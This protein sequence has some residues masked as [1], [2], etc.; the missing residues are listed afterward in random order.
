MT[1]NE[2]KDIIKECIQEEQNDSLTIEESAI[3]NDSVAYEEMM[4]D[5]MIES[6]SL[7]LEELI[8]AEV[9]DSNGIEIGK[10]T[11]ELNNLVGSHVNVN[12]LKLLADKMASDNSGK[13]DIKKKILKEILKQIFNK[14]NMKNNFKKVEDKILPKSKQGRIILGTVTALSAAIATVAIIKANKDKKEK[15]EESKEE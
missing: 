9:I 3:L 5:C 10:T 1:R 4:Y 11:I 6:T 7:L 2:L 13:R 15:S 8:K 12:N 14:N